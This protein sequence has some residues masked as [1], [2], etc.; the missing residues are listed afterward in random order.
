MNTTT[1]NTWVDAESQADAAAKA[2]K[3]E[4][5]THKLEKRL[6]RQVGQAISDFNMIEEGDKVMVCLSGG[7][8]SHALLDILLSLK[9]R[10][11]IRF[12]IVAVNLDQK[13]PG[14]PAHILPEYLQS[15]GVPLNTLLTWQVAQ[16]CVAW[17]P[18]RVNVVPVLW[19]KLAGFQAGAE[20]WWHVSHVVGKPAEACGGLTAFW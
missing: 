9:Q 7:K 8:D 15:R 10:A 11:P 2:V 14:F 17:T 12:D 13:Q 20:N 3:I 1:E 4:R 18:A 16:V 19:L 6:C 5:E